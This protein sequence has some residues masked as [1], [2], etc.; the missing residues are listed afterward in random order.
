M[1]GKQ[2]PPHQRGWPQRSVSPWSPVAPSPPPIIG[3]IRRSSLTYPNPQRPSM[4]GFG[5]SGGE[6]GRSMVS[7]SPLNPPS[8]FHPPLPKVGPS[9]PVQRKTGFTN[10]PK[11][12]RPFNGG[13]GDSSFQLSPTPSP[14][15]WQAT[16]PP[17]YGYPNRPSHP[18]Q[19][20]PFQRQPPPSPGPILSTYSPRPNEYVVYDDDIEYGPSTAE[21]IANQSQ[22]YID[23]KLAEYQM[24][25][26]YLQ[27]K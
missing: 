27:G 23:E 6:D 19:P 22:D 17:Q 25:I 9:P 13:G 24:T 3:G 12:Y 20:S 2:P 10:G 8:A 16:T 18:R 1:S 26:M 5:E 21:I 15:V 14:I 11:P 7:L 4:P